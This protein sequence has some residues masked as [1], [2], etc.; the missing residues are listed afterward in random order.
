[1]EKKTTIVLTTHYLDEAEFLAD[2][3]GVTKY[4]NKF[5]HFVNNFINENIKKRLCLMDSY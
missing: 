3:I 5:L 2:R 1:M 4:I